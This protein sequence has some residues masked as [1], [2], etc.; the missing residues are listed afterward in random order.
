M[1]GLGGGIQQIM[2]FDA[3][4]TRQAKYG[5]YNAVYIVV[6]V[7][8]LAAVNY[9]ADQHNKTFDATANKLYSLSEQNIG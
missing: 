6:V 1:E 5:G 2:N 3:F 9:L 8:I 7:A 4:K